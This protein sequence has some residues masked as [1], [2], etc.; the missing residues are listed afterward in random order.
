MIAMALICRPALLIADEPT[1]ALDVTIQAQILK[2][3]KDLQSELGMAL[4]IITHDLG[5][6]ANMASEVVVMYHGKVM[7]S[8]TLD[9]IFRHPTHPYLQALLRAVPRFHME[10]GERLTPLREIPPPSGRMIAAPPPWPVGADAAGPLLQVS[11]ITKRFRVR[12]AGGPAGTIVA[13]DDVSFEI[14]RGECLGLVGESGCGKTTLSKVIMRALTPDSGKILFNDHGKCVDVL[15]LKGEAL[16]EVPPP[17]PVHLP[18]PLRLAQPAHDGLRH[19][20]RAA[21]D[22]R[23]R[24]LRRAQGSREG[25]DVAGRAECAIPQALPPQLLRRPAPAHRHRARPGPEARPIALRRAG[26]GARRLDPGPGAEPAEGSPGQARP[27]LSLRLAQSGGGRL[28]R[29]PDHGHVRRAHR[30][31]GALG[32]A[33]QEPLASPIPRR[34]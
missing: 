34:C 24:D 6:V 15:D 23:H 3:I 18:G 28:H 9:D 22:P 20:E 7:E 27:H 25:A 19:P 1:T 21:G 12:N 16:T 2:L 32:R 31:G 17:H 33:V 4:L 5:V 8:G 30:R 14:K 26:L 13:V 10:P 29:R 11:G